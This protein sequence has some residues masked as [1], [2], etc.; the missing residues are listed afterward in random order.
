MA[1]ERVRAGLP[2]AVGRAVRRGPPERVQNE[3]EERGEILEGGPRE[4]LVEA[5]QTARERRGAAPGLGVPEVAQDLVQAREGD[6]GE[7]GDQAFFLKRSARRAL[8][9][10]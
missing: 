4:P 5:V 8:S 6:L 3:G 7:R 10:S 2:A 1:E 9:R